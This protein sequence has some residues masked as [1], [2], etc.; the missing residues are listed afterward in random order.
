M[1]KFPPGTQKKLAK[2]SSF[3]YKGE[4]DEASQYFMVMLARLR[5]HVRKNPEMYPNFKIYEFTQQ[6]G[7][8]VF[9]PNGWWHAVLNL[10]DTIGITQNFVSERVGNFDDAWLMTRTGRKRMAWKWLLKLQE[11]YPHLGKRAL[12]LNKQDKFQ[13]KYDPS[14]YQN[15]ANSCSRSPSREFKRARVSESRNAES[16]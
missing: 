14:N 7:E 15:K 4:D 8:T 10:T 2:A 1:C 3:C 9:I 12:E 11:H 16:P 6:A 5:R 13:M